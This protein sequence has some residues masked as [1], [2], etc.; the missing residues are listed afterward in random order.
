MT[1]IETYKE[2]TMI[3]YFPDKNDKSL[4]GDQKKKGK[5]AKIYK[6]EE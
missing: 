4:A 2:R 1:S 3:T 6:H 5:G